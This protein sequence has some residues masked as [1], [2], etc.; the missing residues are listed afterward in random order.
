MKHLKKRKMDNLMTSL[1]EHA[2]LK[3]YQ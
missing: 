3:S 1:R 2:F